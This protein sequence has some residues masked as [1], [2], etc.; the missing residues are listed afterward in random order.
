MVATESCLLSD[1]LHTFF[2]GEGNSWYH[3]GA[4]TGSNCILEGN[5]ADIKQDVLNSNLVLAVYGKSTSGYLPGKFLGP[6]SANG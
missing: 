4:A 3:D 2:D 6:G 1:G 5:M